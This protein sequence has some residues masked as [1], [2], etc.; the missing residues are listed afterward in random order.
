MSTDLAT[1]LDAIPT[2]SF[3]SPDE[4]DWKPLRHHLG[5]GAYGVNAWVAAAPG[6]IVIERHDESP[7]NPGTH[8]HDVLRGAARFTVAFSPSVWEERSLRQLGAAG[9]APPG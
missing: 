7:E 9:A 2:L 1:H 8:G 6:D 4:P 5:I 3:A